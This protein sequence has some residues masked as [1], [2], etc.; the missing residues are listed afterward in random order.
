MKILDTTIRDGSYAIDFKFS[1]D[2][3]RD[4]LTKVEKLNMDY[5]E[6]G[7]GMGLNASSDKHGHSLHTDEEYMQTASD[8]LKK[9]PFGFFCIP[10]IARMDDLKLASE[11]GV[12]FVR[13]GVNANQFEKAIPY[14]EEA[15]K[16]GLTPMMNFMKS[17]IVSPK[18]FASNAKV[19]QESGAECVYLVD[20]SGGMLQTDIEKYY[21]LTREACD[22]KI[23]F[24]GHNNLG[25]AVS[26]TVYCANKGFD[27]IDCS[28]QGLGRSLGNAS[29]EMV[30]MTLKKM[31]WN[32]DIDVP[33]LLEYGYVLL[34]DLKENN[35]YN[36]L[37]LLCG[38]ADFHSSYL[39]DIYKCC[40]EYKVDPLRLIIAYSEY[41]NH[42]FDYGRLC[43]CANTLPKD[44]EKNPYSFRNYFGKNFATI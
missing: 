31:G 1:T 19:A 21:E 22:V 3:V 26:N 4:I 27:I 9:I 35:V 33:R 13:I 16:L 38:Y 8:T 37:D 6:I 10:G 44:L 28:L 5:V 17:Y 14:I 43:E 11:N 7:H 30:V 34:H 36:P 39:K 25:L 32:I 42:N 29:T 20:S 18:E 40:T 24:H 41:D 2:E 12:S 15:K 23:G